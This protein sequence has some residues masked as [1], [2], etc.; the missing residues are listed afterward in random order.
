ME[1]YKNES[2]VDVAFSVLTDAGSTVK[3]K[4]L[5]NLVCE[6]LELSEEEKADKISNFYTNLSLD[7]RFV[8][9]GENEWDLRSRQKY[10]KVHIDMNDVYSDIDDE[11]TGNMDLEEY[12]DEERESEGIVVPEDD[13]DE[14]I[15]YDKSREDL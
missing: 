13:G 15:D 3:F 7:G 8:T 1:N 12:S 9:L 10:E 11:T 4:D 6:K 2:M 5:Y 14:S